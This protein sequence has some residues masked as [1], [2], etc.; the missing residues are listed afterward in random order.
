MLKSSAEAAV[1]RAAMERANAVED[2]ASSSGTAAHMTSRERSAYERYNGTNG[3]KGEK[4][5]WEEVNSSK[6][7]NDTAWA[8]NPRDDKQREYSQGA[9]ISWPNQPAGLSR[10]Y[11]SVSNTLGER[12]RGGPLAVKGL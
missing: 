8:R 5:F 9:R 11:G 2:T 4:R 3:L 10:K 1:H 12:R 6:I 7:V